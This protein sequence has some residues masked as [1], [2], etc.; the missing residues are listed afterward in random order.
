MRLLFCTPTEIDRPCGGRAMLARVHRDA[1]AALVGRNLRMHRVHG[2]A[3]PMKRLLGQVDGAT[4]SHARSVIAAVEAHDAEALWLDGSNLGYLAA[5]VRKAKPEV[6]IITFCHNVEARF[7]LG[8]LRRIPGARA[9]GVLIG[10]YAAE[11]LAMRNSSDVVTLSDR[12]DAGLR[13]LYGRG[14]DHILPMA[15]TDQADGSPAPT[16]LDDGAPLLFVGGAFYANQAG[17]AWFARHVAPRIQIPTHVVGQG[18]DAM[19]ASL[20]DT[21]NVRVLGA[22]DRLA[23]LYDRARLVIA[24][25]FDGSGMKTKVAEA[26]MFGKHVAGTAEAFSGYAADVLAANAL[27][28]DADDFVEAVRAPAPPAYDP[29]MRAL[30]ERDHSPRAT[31]S[32]LARILGIDQ[33]SSS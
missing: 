12:D 24:P 6:R 10:N 31:R 20:E 16:P 22:V 9:A 25:I 1:L 8:A 4:Q 23:P 15:L 29:A 30:Y 28:T 14:A 7:F 26:L 11:R 3:G 32:R 18:M 27:C 2:T 33:T 13:R 19:R 17:I 21:A 5:A